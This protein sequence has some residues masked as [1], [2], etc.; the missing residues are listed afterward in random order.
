MIKYDIQCHTSH[1]LR[2][3]EVRDPQYQACAL[4]G[5]R[6]GSIVVPGQ[7]YLRT[8]FNYSQS[9]VGLN[10]GVI[11]AS[12]IMIFGG[13][14]GGV[15]L[16]PQTKF[17][18]RQIKQDRPPQQDDTE[19]AAAGGS[20]S[21]FSLAAT[22][23]NSISAPH[24]AAFTTKENPDNMLHG[25]NISGSAQS[26]NNKPIF[27]WSDIN[28]ELQSGHKLLQH[29]D[30]WVCLGQMTALWVPVVQERQHS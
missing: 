28:L 26:H 21:H 10:S 19:A 30:G 15:I 20:P 13:S 3:N 14:G 9:S 25:G 29:V 23:A 16:F 22:P 12:E 7:D 5:S 4:T 2:F 1:I 11:I 6:P 27:T 18:H 8:T 24:P 17:V